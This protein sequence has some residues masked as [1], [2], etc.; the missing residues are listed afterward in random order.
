MRNQCLVWRNAV[1]ALLA[2]RKQGVLLQLLSATG[3]SRHAQHGFY[4]FGVAVNGG[5]AVR[6]LLIDSIIFLS[7]AVAQG[8]RI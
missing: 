7:L 5:V 6:G 1:G 2:W 3:I 8:C 4:G